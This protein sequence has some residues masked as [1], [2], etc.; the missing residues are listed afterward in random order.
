MKAIV[1]AAG[2]G[3]RLG[4]AA[5]MLPKPMVP[6]RG[7]PVL[8][9]NIRWL[10]SHGITDLYL[11][12]HHLPEIIT[13]H[14]DDGAAFGVSIHYSLEE[15]LLGTAGAVRRIADR[16]WK[17]AAEPFLVIYGDNLL[18]YNLTA[19]QGFHRE[20]GGAGTIVVYE[21]EDVLQSGIVVTDATAR[22][23]TFIE[24]P[25]PEQV[26]SHLVNTGIYVLE[27]AVVDA[28][29]RETLVD[30]GRDV[31]PSL[32]ERGCALYAMAPPGSLTA[33]D[34]PELLRQ[35]TRDAARP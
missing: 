26:V 35:A 23:L 33:I 31:F 12:L 13:D 9:H 17:D 34:T 32:L 21:K 2:K 16:Y 27:P 8:E 18:S 29:P 5:G 28:I 7:R 11:N 24:K 19:V 10:R 25:R 4:E 3:T 14:F 15:N 1:L 22:I 30:F 6:V 20:K